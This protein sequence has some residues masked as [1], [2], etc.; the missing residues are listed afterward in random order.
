MESRISKFFQYYKI[1]GFIY[2]FEFLI[3][4]ILTL[5]TTQDI[6][7]YNFFLRFLFWFLAGLYYQRVVFK[8][9]SFFSFKY[10][11]TFFLGPALAAWIFVFMISM[12]DQYISKFISD[13]ISSLACYFIISKNFYIK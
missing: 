4:Y 6:V 11:I 2:F 10:L 3:F 7:I 9:V 8:N 12:F 13:L 5:S 1:S